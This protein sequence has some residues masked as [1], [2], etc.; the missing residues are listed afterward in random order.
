MAR[1]SPSRGHAFHAG[2]EHIIACSQ[3]DGGNGVCESGRGG[4]LDQSDVIVNG[5]GV[6]VRMSEHLG[7]KFRNVCG[8]TVRVFLI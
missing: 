5:A 6:P 3:T 2:G 4:Q 8:F 1:Q 7:G